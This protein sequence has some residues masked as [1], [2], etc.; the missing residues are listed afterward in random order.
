MI[1]R[2]HDAKYAVIVRVVRRMDRER[3]KAENEAAAVASSFKPALFAKHGRKYL[4]KWVRAV[5]AKR[6]KATALSAFK[7]GKQNAKEF[8]DEE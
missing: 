6:L 7:V 1:V 3:R 2:E 4:M 8:R 5:L